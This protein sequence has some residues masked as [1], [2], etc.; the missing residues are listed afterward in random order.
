MLVLVLF[1]I[2]RCAPAPSAGF[3]KPI[4][5][6][7]VYDPWAMFIGSEGPIFTVYESGHVLYW[8][9]K[10]YHKALLSKGE[11]D[12]LFQQFRLKDTFFLQSRY[13]EASTATDQ[14]S[15][16]LQL[17]LDTLKTFLVYGNMQ[18]QDSRLKIPA[19]LL[20]AYTKATT[21]SND[22]AI[23]WLPDKVE[24]MLTDYSNSPEKPIPWPA[25]WP[26][27]K[28]RSTRLREGGASLYLEPKHFDEFRRMLA[29]LKERQAFLI[30]GKLFGAGYRL[31]IP[32]VDS[33][34]AA[35]MRKYR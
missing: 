27:L 9:N 14:P 24:V 3:G 7:T 34:L 10:R 18:N 2:I 25:G 6:Y 22:A 1:V 4:L 11:L 29:S 23:D 20:N 16:V 33:V 15:Y 8:A 5:W 35:E 32:G 31:P 19:V 21:Y 13:I 28:S 12:G 30:S 26:D 17:N